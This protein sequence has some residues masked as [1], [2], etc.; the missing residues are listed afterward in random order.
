MDRTLGIRDIG[1]D[2][3]LIAGGGRAILL[4]IAHPAVGRGV[5]EHSDFVSDPMRR[6]RSTLTFVYASV[7]GS[8]RELAAVRK[9]VNRAHAPVHSV[10][11][12][13]A[14]AQPYDAFDPQLQLWVAATLYETAIT[15]HERVF[16]PLDTASADRVYREYAVLGTSLQVP[17]SLWPADRAAFREYWNAKVA[18]LDVTPSTRAVAHQL[19][20]ARDLPALL[21]AAMPVARLVTTGLL[22]RELVVAF[23]LPWNRT[24]QRRFDELM[25]FTSAVY[26]PLPLWLRHRPRDLLLNR[27]RDSIEA[28]R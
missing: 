25:R 7:Y 17:E 27:L 10:D 24:R 13:E 16:G 26:P 21:R 11:A 4:Q 28:E 20:H 22:P 1:A 9:A 19:L 8:P 6:L 18:S 5:A 3:V 2:A 14:A 23:G 15:V 12:P